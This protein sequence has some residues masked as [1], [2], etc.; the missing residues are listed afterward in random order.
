MK[1]TRFKK[2]GYKKN[3]QE[4]H[5]RKTYKKKQNKNR[6][7]KILHGGY[8]TNE[9]INKKFNNYPKAE[10]SLLDET[11]TTNIVKKINENIP[12]CC[13]NTSIKYV[14]ILKLFS[15]DW[16]KQ[17]FIVGGAVRDYMTTKSIQTMNDIDINYTLNPNEINDD[18]FKKLNITNYIKDERNYIR[19]G[20]KS[21]DDYL[22]G[23]YINPFETFDYQLECK[24]NSL[25]FMIDFDDSTKKYSIYLVD[26]FGGLAL[27]QAEDKIW[28]A[29]TNDYIKWLNTTKKLLWRLI[30][31]ELRGYQVPFETKQNVYSYFIEDTNIQDYTWQN[32]W[33]TISPDKLNLVIGLIIK[34]CKEVKLEPTLLIQKLI[35]KRLIIANK[36]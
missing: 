19:V 17:I 20:P 21:R 30:K 10:F 18:M 13:G 8:Y 12:E 4:K 5:T 6:L 3:K 33:W 29:P 15:E 34:D 16:T 31:F 9:I 1:K 26:L 24:M 28:E 2:K 23:F 35:D 11:D 36:Q 27:K 22:E 32:L 25:M 14:D 7:S